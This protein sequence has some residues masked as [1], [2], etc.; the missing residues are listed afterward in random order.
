M[1]KLLAA[2]LIC[3]YLFTLLACKETKPSITGPDNNNLKPDLEKINAEVVQT[4][5]DF[6]LQLFKTINTTCPDSNI[7]IAPLSVSIALG[8]AL[9]GAE[10]TTRDEIITMLNL[11]G[12][13]QETINET[14]QQ[15]IT[16]LA[17]NE[18]KVL[19]EIAN[20]V[21]YD[22]TRM[23]P[24][25]DFLNVNQKFFF[26]D[27]LNLNFSQ[28]GAVDSINNWISDKTHGKIENMLDQIPGSAVLYLINA[29]YFYGQWLYT[30]DKEKTEE[31]DFFLQGGAVVQCPLM[32]QKSEYYYYENEDIQM[33][34]MKYA[35]E[36]YSMTLILPK[37]DK[38]I[39]M[40]IDDLSPETWSDWINLMDKDSVT[41]HLPK[42]KTEYKRTLNEDLKALGMKLAFT[43]DADFSGIAPGREIWISRVLHKALIEVNEE[44]SEAAAA[45]IIEF[46][47][48]SIPMHP[49]MFINRPFFFVI[50]EHQTNTIL[51]M[52][53]IMNPVE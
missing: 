16:L 24:E 41:V 42:F 12:M 52:G 47:E 34:D 28:A 2:A 1:K 27:V 23:I 20:S 39:N 45:T 17:G 15:L 40:I 9:N 37:Y 33:L 30:F 5:N 46:I 32:N 53:K 35:N 51:F 4:N 25:Q 43:P 14:Y 10:G 19:F 48:L 38:D 8:M 13:S 44:G 50:R 3:L 26:A 18:E 29:L 36:A 7:F 31:F 49:E 21:W 11:G 22:Q 6:G